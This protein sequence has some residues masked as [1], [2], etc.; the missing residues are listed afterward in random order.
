MITLA[1]ILA[2]EGGQPQS[3]GTPAAGTE[4][5]GAPATGQPAQPGMFEG[6]APLLLFGVVIV[7][8]MFFMTRSKKRQENEHKKKI[9]QLETGARVMLTSGLIARVDKID[10]ENQEARLLVDEDK[11]VHETYNIMAIAKV[12]E[13]KK[14]SVKED[15]K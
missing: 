1:T 12:F 9:E 14:S 8:F 7:V 2:Q 5:P 4:Q 6:M 11:K 3:G 10:R 13:E 15:D